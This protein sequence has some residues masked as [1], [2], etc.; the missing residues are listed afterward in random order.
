M[1]G[2]SV[3]LWPTETHSTS[4]ERSKLFLLTQLLFKS[5]EP[6]LKY[7]ISVQSTLIL[8]SKGAIFVGPNCT[9]FH[10]LFSV[11]GRTFMWCDRQTDIWTDSLF[12]ENIILDFGTFY[13]ML[14]E[15]EL[16]FCVC[17]PFEILICPGKNRKCELRS[18]VLVTTLWRQL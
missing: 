10:W 12:S 15:I 8:S 16:I 7:F 9:M 13:K 2:I 5:L 4:L 3:A 6:H 1:A 14:T 17:R 11:M 18:Y